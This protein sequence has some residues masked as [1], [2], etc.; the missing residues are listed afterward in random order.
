VGN[1]TE[2]YKIMEMMDKV[3]AVLILFTKSSW[4]KTQTLDQTKH[5]NTDFSYNE[6]LEFNVTRIC[7]SIQYCQI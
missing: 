1:M 7:G 6:L 5:K 3:I 4:A 2:V